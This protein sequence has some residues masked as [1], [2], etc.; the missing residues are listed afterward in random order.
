MLNIYII[1]KINLLNIHIN[2]KIRLD[3][4]VIIVFHLCFFASSS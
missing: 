1:I 2:N 4:D 3:N